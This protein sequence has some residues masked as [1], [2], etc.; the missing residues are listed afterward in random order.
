MGDKAEEKKEKK[1]AK[2]D[3]KYTRPIVK[4][5]EMPEDMKEEALNVAVT[6]FQEHRTE[7]KIAD[8]IKQH[9]DSH[10]TPTWN[11]IVGKSF[12]AFVTHET[13]RYLYFAIGHMSILLWKCG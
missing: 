3:T 9:M 1:D 6:A 11:C 12:G 5:H 10:H 13:K 2:G 7:K 4:N 8:T